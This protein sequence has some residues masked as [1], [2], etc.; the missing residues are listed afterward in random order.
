MGAIKRTTMEL[1]LDD[2]DDDGSRSPLDVSSKDDSF[3]LDDDDMAKMAAL[4]PMNSDKKLREYQ[5][6]LDEVLATNM[7]MMFADKQTLKTINSRTIKLVDITQQ[8]DLEL[9]E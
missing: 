2:D 8:L 7:D 4:L 1:F 9:E 5:K 6:A 3:E